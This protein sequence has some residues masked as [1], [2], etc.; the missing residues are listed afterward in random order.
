MGDDF[1]F[2]ALS[3]DRLDKQVVVR[4]NISVSECA[5]VFQGQEL[6]VILERDVVALS[7]AF[8]TVGCG[9]TGLGTT[10]A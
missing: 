9:R 10:L 3:A 8:V 4:Q 5:H 6:Q 2:A 1:G 7:G